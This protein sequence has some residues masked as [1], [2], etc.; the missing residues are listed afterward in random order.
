MNKQDWEGL[1]KQL[2]IYYLNFREYY[3]TSKNGSN[4]KIREQA[5]KDV[6]SEIKLAKR[7][8]EKYP[9]SFNLMIGE[10]D[11]GDYNRAIVW[12]E[13]FKLDYFNNDMEE[14]LKKIK[15]KIESIE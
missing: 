7:Y 2:E 8:I 4:Q 5:S 15:D 6:T 3:N 13:F 1:Y 10:E 11:V 12:D 9:E 14:F